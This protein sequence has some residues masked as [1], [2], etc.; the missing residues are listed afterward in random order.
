[1]DRAAAAVLVKNMEVIKAYSEGK[2]AQWFNGMEW[3]DLKDPSF[4]DVDGQYRVK[5]EPVKVKVK[6]FK[7]SDGTV[8]PIT[9][10]CWE[11]FTKPYCTCVSDVYELEVKEK[12]CDC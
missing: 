10:K 2:T 6:L 11:H 8:V 4:N 1:M 3:K 12:Q 9:E 7:F 5:P